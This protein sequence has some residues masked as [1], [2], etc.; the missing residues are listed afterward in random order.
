MPDLTPYTGLALTAERFTD[1]HIDTIHD[2]GFTGRT[3]FRNA[4]TP[5]RGDLL[6][7]LAQGEW[8]RPQQRGTFGPAARIVDMTDTHRLHTARFV[9]HRAVQMLLM[10]PDAVK[11]TPLFVALLTAPPALPLPDAPGW[12]DLLGRAAHWSTCPR[13]RNLSAP[14]CGLD[15]KANVDRWRDGRPRELWVDYSGDAAGVNGL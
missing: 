11:V 5:P 1:S 6:S 7:L 14:G 2:D 4:S 15:C 13:N 8:W 10:T 12:G 3:R 9:L